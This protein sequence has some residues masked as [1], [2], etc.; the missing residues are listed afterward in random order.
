MKFNNEILQH[1]CEYPEY[2]LKIQKNCIERW[3]EGVDRRIILRQYK[4]CDENRHLNK[5]EQC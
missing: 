3:A 5:Q 1:H 4:C 2:D